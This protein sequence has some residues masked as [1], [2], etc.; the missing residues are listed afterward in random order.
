MKKKTI[1]ELEEDIRE[2]KLAT[3]ILVIIGII[4]VILS[5]VFAISGG[6]RF[7]KIQELESQLSDCQE[8]VEVWTLETECSYPDEEIPI[9]IYAQYNFTNYTEYL[10]VKEEIDKLDIC[11]VIE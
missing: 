4:F 10:G 9:Y 5:L 11:E 3:Y 6:N 2:W 7:N 1:A 8:N